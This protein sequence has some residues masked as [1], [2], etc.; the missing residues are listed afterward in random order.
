MPNRCDTL[1]RIS[2]GR[3]CLVVMMTTPF[4]AREP[5]SA[6]AD[7]PFRISMLA[8]SFGLMSTSRLTGASWFDAFEP[9]DASVIAFAFDETA[10][11][12][13]IMPSTT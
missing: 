3:P 2:P 4:A 8:M 7:A 6:A 9:P 13:M 12:L 10:T 5:Y 11:L 1:M